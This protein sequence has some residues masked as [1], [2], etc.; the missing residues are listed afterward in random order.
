MEEISP[1]RIKIAMEMAQM[2]MEAKQDKE[3]KV[4]RAYPVLMASPLG[5]QGLLGVQGKEAK[6]LIEKDKAMGLQVKPPM[7]SQLPKVELVLKVPKIQDPET[8]NL[9]ELLQE[10]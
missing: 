5:L 6:T 7:D 10:E 9:M 1:E 3:A 2:P 8:F 4:P